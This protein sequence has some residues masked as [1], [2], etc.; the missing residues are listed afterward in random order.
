MSNSVC[1]KEC[2]MKRVK[3][4]KTVI[5][6]SFSEFDRAVNDEIEKGFEPFGNPY[7]L[8]DEK[9]FVCQAMVKYES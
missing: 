3:A 9:F 7:E 6:S 5:K 8:D 4:Y 2:K 1:T